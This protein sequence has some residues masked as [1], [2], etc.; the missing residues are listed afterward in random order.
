MRIAITGANGFVGSNLLAAFEAIGVHV[1][2][3]ARR[4]MPSAVW[5]R[6]PLLDRDIDPQEWAQAFAGIDVVVHLA[7]RAHVMRDDAVDPLDVFRR[8]NRDGAVAMAR[9]AAMAGVRRIVFLSTVKVLGETT[10]GR[11]PFHNDD[12]VAPLDPYAISKSEAEIALGE[13]ARDLGIELV[14]LRPPLV[15]G[16]GVGGNIAALQRLIRRGIWLPL[17]AA[18]S[19]GRSMISTGNLS[20]AIHAATRAPAAVGQK[21]LVSDGDDVSTRELLCRLSAIEGRRARLISVPPALLRRVL[22]LLGRES[23]WLRLFGDLRVDI[24]QS[25]SILEWQPHLDVAEGMAGMADDGMNRIPSRRGRSPRGIFHRLADILLVVAASPVVVPVCAVLLLVIKLDSAGNALF[26]QNRVGAGRKPFRLMK[27]RTMT[28]DTGDLPSH[29]V[30][31][32]KVTR[33]GRFLRRTKLDELPQLWNV[34]KG[35]MTFVGPRPCL[36]SQQHVIDVR[37]VRGLFN[38]LPGITGPA[39]IAGID[40]ATPERMAHVEAAY[41]SRATTRSDI[42]L[43]IRTVFGAGRGDVVRW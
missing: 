37:E 25:M 27:L 24:S 4:E 20:A 34:L 39:Q 30:A 26:I 17:G 28:I 3:L 36:P 40:M 6:S 43:V 31:S 1:V 2:A 15:Y 42:M 13:V 11:G 35:E 33:V 19:N 16:P 21:L 5:R 8:V 41:F 22:S 32:S 18:G 38:I 9:G 10:S 12:A 7:A 14:V 23:L 29:T